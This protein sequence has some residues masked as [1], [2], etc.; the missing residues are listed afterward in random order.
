[1]RACC[2]S[3]SPGEAASVIFAILSVFVFLVFVVLLL[4]DLP[5][6]L[7]ALGLVLGLA[8]AFVSAGIVYGSVQHGGGWR[9]L[10]Q[11]IG[12]TVTRPFRK[13]SD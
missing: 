8:V 13:S 12:Q 5:V 2:S 4:A 7:K 3:V 9:A 10:F 1:M 6:L 11:R